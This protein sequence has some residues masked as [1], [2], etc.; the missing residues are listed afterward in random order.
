MMMQ[1]SCLLDWMMV[2]IR[3]DTDLDLG[4]SFVWDEHVLKKAEGKKKGTK[5][6]DH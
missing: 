5:R 1:R 3:Y 4:V 6:S 2:G